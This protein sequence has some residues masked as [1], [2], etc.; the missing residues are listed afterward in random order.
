MYAAADSCCN[1]NVPLMC[2]CSDRAACAG[3]TEV[4]A[5]WLRS[6]D[7]RALRTRALLAT[8]RRTIHSGSP[9]GREESR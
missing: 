9:V 1:E 2:E 4:M 5:L 8:Q 3:C 6:G 7:G